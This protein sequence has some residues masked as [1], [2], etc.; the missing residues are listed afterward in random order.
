[1]DGTS[2]SMREWIVKTDTG[3][4]G[5]ARAG[6]GPRFGRVGQHGETS[7]REISPRLTFGGTHRT[8][9][10]S[11]SGSV[12]STKPLGCAVMIGHG[13]SLDMSSS[14]TT[15][16]AA[17]APR[18]EAGPAGFGFGCPAICCEAGR[19]SGRRRSAR[20]CEATVVPSYRSG[21]IHVT[22]TLMRLRASVTACRRSCASAYLCSPRRHPGRFSSAA[23]QQRL[24]IS[25]LTA[26]EMSGRKNAN[27]HFADCA[28]LL[29]ADFADLLIADFADL[30][31]DYRARSIF[32]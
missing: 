12:L 24:R 10:V 27:G 5:C 22:W 14:A 8:S 6:R 16:A 30:L 4:A 9:C 28:N 26:S 19:D 13:T 32:G 21:V 18:P 3:R 2:G 15:V 1:M 23:R 29:I 7:H 31:I 25:S 11:L 17:R 20:A